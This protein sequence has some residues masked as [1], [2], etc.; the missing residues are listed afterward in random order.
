MTNVLTEAYQALNEAYEKYLKKEEASAK[1]IEGLAC[2]A[3][4]SGRPVVLSEEFLRFHN[5]E[6]KD[7]R[8]GY[9]NAIAEAKSRLDKELRKELEGE[10]LGDMLKDIM[11]DNALDGSPKE[12]APLATPSALK[13]T[14]KKASIITDEAILGAA[15]S[16]KP[17][18]KSESLASRLSRKLAIEVEDDDEY[19]EDD[20]EVEVSEEAPFGRTP[21]GEYLDPDE[22]LVY[23]P[24][25]QLE[26][27]L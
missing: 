18:S 4:A 23:S 21:S 14:K 1:Y 2:L 26:V 6:L 5:G 9:K 27:C 19:D 13:P 7:A 10:P 25:D 24:D 12:E 15:E 8:A 17:E 3:E 11:A 16:D 22:K 20:D